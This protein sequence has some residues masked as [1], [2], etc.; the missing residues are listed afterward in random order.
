MKLKPRSFLRWFEVD[1]VS[2][3][4]GAV[5]GGGEERLRWLNEKRLHLLLFLS[6]LSAAQRIL[7]TVLFYPFA[8]SLVLLKVSSNLIQFIKSGRRFEMLQ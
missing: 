6:L 1:T 8:I 3:V 2:D 5:N 7:Q 4:A